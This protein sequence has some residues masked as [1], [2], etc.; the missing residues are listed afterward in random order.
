VRNWT[1]AGEG[2]GESQRGAEEKERRGRGRT[3]GVVCVAV[4]VDDEVAL[5]DL[6]WPPLGLVPLPALLA[7]LLGLLDLLL[8]A[9]ARRRRPAAGVPAARAQARRPA[10]PARRGRRVGRAVRRAGGAAVAAWGGRARVG[11]RGRRRAVGLVAGLADA[12]EAVG[13]VAVDIGPALPL[14][15]RREDARGALVA[16]ELV[17]AGPVVGVRT[18][19]TGGLSSWFCWL[20]VRGRRA[21]CGRG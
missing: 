11:G 18:W 16:V 12:A 7:L 21:E 10:V 19:R 5:L 20:A 4:L 1:S 15:R 3:F 14:A 9:P 13:G 6:V 17:A 2:R 8:Q